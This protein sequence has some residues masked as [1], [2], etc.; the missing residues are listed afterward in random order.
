[1]ASLTDNHKGLTGKFGIIIASIKEKGDGKM[2]SEY[3]EGERI[4]EEIEGA[5]RK[6]ALENKLEFKT[7]PHDIA[8]WVVN[9]LT[10]RRKP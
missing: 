7:P 10:K 9:E 6:I 3:G 2:I 8:T 1:M 4:A 5:I